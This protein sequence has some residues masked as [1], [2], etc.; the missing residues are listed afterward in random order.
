MTPQVQ[1]LSL[2]QL[3]PDLLPPTWL[4]STVIFAARTTHDPA[5]DHDLLERVAQD[6]RQ[7]ARVLTWRS[8]KRR[9]HW[10]A[11]RLAAMAVGEA[12]GMGRA[13][14][15]T[16][17]TGSPL[18]VAGSHRAP[19]SITHSGDWALAAGASGVPLLGLDYEVGIGDKLYLKD[20]I[21]SRREQVLYGL[22]DPEVDPRLQASRLA[23]VWVLKEAVLKA[24]GVGLVVGL[25]DIHVTELEW[26]APSRFEAIRPLH[27]VIPHP[28]PEG[29][30]GGVTR[31]EGFPLALVA[32]PSSAP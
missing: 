28:L 10:L 11:G 5:Q 24:F 7:A 9:Q 21:C 12:M 17:R 30:W 13:R 20:R 6:E 22:G 26:S 15:D 1:R 25:K 23:R 3:F 4:R 19:V 16:T 18:L 32:A 8:D 31:F 27:E 2:S 14:V 29:L